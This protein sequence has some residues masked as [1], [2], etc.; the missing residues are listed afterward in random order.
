MVV[1]IRKTNYNLEI[2]LKLGH[3][4]MRFQQ[5]FQSSVRCIT[6][7]KYFLLYLITVAV[8]ANS[9]VVAAHYIC[10]TVSPE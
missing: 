2:S 5:A 6:N 3:S 10:V 9:Y 7:R 8:V 4:L 1:S